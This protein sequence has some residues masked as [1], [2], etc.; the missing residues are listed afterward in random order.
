MSPFLFI[1]KGQSLQQQI[2]SQQEKLQ[3]CLACP[4]V[5]IPLENNCY[6]FSNTS[7][8]FGAAKEICNRAGA[9]ILE[10]Q[11]PREKSLTKTKGYDKMWIGVTDNRQEGVFVYESTG[12][13]VNNGDWVKGQP[14]GGRNENC[15]VA[16]KDSNWQWHD[17]PCNHKFD[18][19]CKKTKGTFKM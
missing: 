2:H 11:S 7:A 9:Y 17:Y 18:Y 19:V 16:Y 5:W 10:D 14:G 1:D 6:L 3:N 15:A 4:D 8:T 12:T 13:R